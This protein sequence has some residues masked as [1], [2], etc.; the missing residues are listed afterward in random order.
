MPNHRTFLLHPRNRP[1]PPV[2]LKHPSVIRLPA[3]RRIQQR[4][5][6]R[7][8][9]LPAPNNRRLKL[10]QVRI[11][12]IQQLS[13][14]NLSHAV[15]LLSQPHLSR[16]PASNV[17]AARATCGLVLA[18]GGKEGRCVRSSEDFGSERSERTT[19][20]DGRAGPPDRP[21]IQ[22]SSSAFSTTSDSAGWMY[23][24][25]FAISSTVWPN[26]MP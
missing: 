21:T 9:P 26:C 25:P 1:A 8:R 16:P 20:R 23:S 15:T 2:T 22:S 4:P 13:R 6:Q 3:T 17:H 19:E 7:H 18:D 24:C 11:P 14:T 12:Q 10:R 5:I